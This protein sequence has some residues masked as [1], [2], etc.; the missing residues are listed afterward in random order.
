M[1]CV[2]HAKKVNLQN[3]LLNKKNVISTS[4]P[5]ELLHIDLFGPVKA[6]SNNGMKYGLVIV[7]DYS[8]WTW[9]KLLRHK[10][11]SHY[12][13]FTFCNQV[14]NKKD[15]RIVKVKS[16]HGGEFENKSFEKFF[17]LRYSSHTDMPQSSVPYPLLYPKIFPPIFF[18]VYQES[19]SNGSRFLKGCT[20]QMPP[21]PVKI[22]VLILA[23][24]LRF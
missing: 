13:C 2:K 9:V 5:L 19:S 24:K 10:D 1:L 23:K 20:V 7:D 11:E 17:N 21:K 3:P 16:N 8:K 4:R 14:Q 12:V 6:T 15:F 22:R 18:K